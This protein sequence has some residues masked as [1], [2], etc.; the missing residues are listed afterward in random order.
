MR[1][2]YCYLKHIFHLLQSEHIYLSK[3][4]SEALWKIVLWTKSKKLWKNLIYIIGQ[5]FEKQLREKSFF[6]EIAASCSNTI[7]LKWPSP[8]VFLVIFSLQNNYLTASTLTLSFSTVT[9]VFF[10]K[11]E[12]ITFKSFLNLPKKPKRLTKI[13]KLK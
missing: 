12:F 1:L 3:S 13:M 2:V 11:A 7:K 10:D 5:V 9:R 6:T 8:L 4:Y